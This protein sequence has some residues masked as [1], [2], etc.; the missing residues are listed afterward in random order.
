MGAQS[1][2]AERASL[3]VTGAMGRESPDF[4]LSKQFVATIAL[5]F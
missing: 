2:G 3:A 1:K 4:K 5:K